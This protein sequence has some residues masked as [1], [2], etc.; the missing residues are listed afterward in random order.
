MPVRVVITLACRRME[1]GAI[2]DRNPP[3]RIFDYLA[4]LQRLCRSRYRRALYAKETGE[5]LLG[6]IHE[7]AAHSILDRQEPATAALFDGV[8]SIACNR[9]HGLR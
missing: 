2:S 6:D 1:C 7:A 5:Q 4:V 3:A 8:R 9:L